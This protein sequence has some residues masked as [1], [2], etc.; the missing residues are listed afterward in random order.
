MTS[1]AVASRALAMG[2]AERRGLQAARIRGAVIALLGA[3]ALWAARGAFN[4]QAKFSF[5]LLEQGGD[6]WSIET[7]VGMLWLVAGAAAIIIGSVQAG[8]GASF[9]WRQSLFVLAP[10]FVAAILGA[11]LDG[12]VANMTG[13]FAGSLELAVPITLGALAGILSERSGMLNIAIEGKFLVGA[14]AAPSLR[15]LQTVPLP[16]W[17]LLCCVAW[18]WATCWPGWASAIKWIR[19]PAGAVRSPRALRASARSGRSG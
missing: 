7:T 6:A 11:L 3:A 16:A 1:V 18:L 10:L 4:V 14:C 12:K 8:V 5:W 9:P 15:A 17:W 13:V 2:E 19:S